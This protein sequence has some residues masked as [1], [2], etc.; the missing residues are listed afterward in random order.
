MAILRQRRSVVLLV[1]PHGNDRSMYAEFLRSQGVRTICPVRA[2][3]AL[4]IAARADVIVTG[5][6]LD[7]TIDGIELVTRLRTDERTKHAPIIVLTA[8]AWQTERDRAV[9][10]GCDVFLSKPCLPDDLLREIRRLLATGRVRGTRK[11]E[12]QKS[13]LRRRRSRPTS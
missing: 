6:L 13:D 2:I 1:Q 7:E 8:C 12:A 3:N 9:G 4:K 5:V 10:A 11:S